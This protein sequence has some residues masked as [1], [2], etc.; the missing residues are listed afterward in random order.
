MLENMPQR[1]KQPDLS[2]DNRSLSEFAQF[3]KERGFSADQMRVA[4]YRS[5][6]VGDP[7]S[8]ADDPLVG[9]LYDQ[10]KKMERMQGFL[11]TVL[12]SLSKQKRTMRI[13]WRNASA[14]SMLS[15]FRTM[16]KRCS[17]QSLS[18]SEP[19]R[20]RSLPIAKKWQISKYTSQP[21]FPE[22]L[23]RLDFSMR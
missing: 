4:Y 19:A 6:G 10:M 23:S 18:D 15:P 20:C 7:E 13:R 8:S 3:V 1:A 17:V 21:T 12:R 5:L 22:R 2:E 14:S 9:E 11:S 16:R